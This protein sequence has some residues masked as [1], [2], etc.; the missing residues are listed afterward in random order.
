MPPGAAGEK[1]CYTTQRQSRTRAEDGGRLC[2]GGSTVAT[3]TARATT[4]SRSVNTG[5]VASS[6]DGL[7]PMREATAVCA[8]R[9]LDWQWQPATLRGAAVI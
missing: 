3:R 8:M 5:E 9:A 4:A 1:L 7:T 2:G 6:F